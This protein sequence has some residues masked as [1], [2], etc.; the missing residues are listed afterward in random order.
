[1]KKTRENDKSKDNN[2]I[3][4]FPGMLEED[5]DI[6]DILREGLLKDAD[7]FEK[8]INKNPD[9]A[10]IEAPE[11]MFEN[12]VAELKKNGIWEEGD[13]EKVTEEIEMKPA[14][15]SKAERYVLLTEDEVDAIRIGQRVKKTTV[16]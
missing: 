9:L 12:I 16:W 10:D 15:L 4:Y 13:E 11:D 2:K 7:A 1:M 8:E 6:D 5:D 14:E 3:E